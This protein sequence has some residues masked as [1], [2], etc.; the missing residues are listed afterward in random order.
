MSMSILLYLDLEFLEQTLK[1]LTLSLQENAEYFTTRSYLTLTLY[2]ALRQG[3]PVLFPGLS[4]TCKRT[5]FHQQYE[6][7]RELLG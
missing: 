6:P 7:K 1:T 5:R 4:G 3:K 2:P